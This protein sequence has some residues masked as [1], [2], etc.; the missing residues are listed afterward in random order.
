MVAPFV[1][2]LVLIAGTPLLYG[3]FWGK[4]RN[5][6]VVAMAVSC[7][8]IVYLL[9]RHPGGTHLLLD[10]CREYLAFMALLASLFAISGGIYLR[11][12][13]AG[14]PLVNT[15]FLG[16]GGLLASVIGTT[17]ASVLL[18]RPLLRANVKRKRTAHIF[19]FFI[20]I[21]S[22]GAGL[23]TPLGDP[24]LFL[25]FLR[26]VP[27]LWTL[28]LVAP[29]AVSNGVLV[30]LFSFID[31]GILNKEERQRP[32][33]QLEEVQKVAEPLSLQG[34]L[35]LLWLLGVVGVIYVVGTYGGAISDNPLVPWALQ[36][37]GML[38]FAGLSLWTTPRSIHEA[39][40]FGWGPIVEVAVVFVGIFLTMVP[41]LAVLQA[42]GTA[43]GIARPWQFFWASGILSSFLDN[44][45][46]YLTFASVA[47]G[48]VNQLA[49]SS[50]EAA[51][52]GALAAH[53][54]GATFLAA[55]SCGSV[56]MGAVT[57][58]GNGPNFMVKAIAEENHV[59]MP[60]FFG[61]MAWS[62]GILIPLF[63]V[64]TFL[65]F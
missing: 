12:S 32:G 23:L 36:V 34:R 40:N 17:G 63:I 46:T 55:V 1:A 47:T 45:P 33:A 41:A 31:Q 24:P 57:Y 50:L 25:G 14:T 15:A 43:L 20:F 44:A 3:E 58:I 10:A 13:L 22:N 60:S 11:G 9:L 64:M 2:Y 8:V 37:G 6:L 4:N 59:R 29:W 30:L 7:P 16:V 54:L 21:V 48:V 65:F 26:G 35:N 49:G 38:A 52:L 18:I 62:V 5:K 56:L 27:F 19:V 53:P 51:N 39:N 28:R 61:Y 42:K